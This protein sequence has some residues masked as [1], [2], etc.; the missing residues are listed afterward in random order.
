[1]DNTPAL[2]ELPDDPGRF[3]F[4]FAQTQDGYWTDFPRDVDG[5]A[6]ITDS[7]DD[8]HTCLYIV[9]HTF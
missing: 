1:M 5:K 7:R 9:R 8:N 3:V 2:I 6:N 4:E